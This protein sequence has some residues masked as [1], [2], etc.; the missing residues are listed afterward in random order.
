MPRVAAPDR[1]TRRDLPS[2]GPTQQFRPPAMRRSA[3][4]AAPP[5]PMERP[6]PQ[7]APPPQAEIQHLL[8]GLAGFYRCKADAQAAMQQLRQVHG[9]QSAQLVLLGPADGA[10]L[11]FIW[12]ARQWN[13]SPQGTGRPITGPLVS[14][15]LAGALVGLVAGLAFLDID[16]HQSIELELELAALAAAVLCGAALAAGAV[17]LLRSQQPQY[18]DFDRTVRRKLKGGAWTVLVHRL[19]WAQQSG[20]VAAVRRQGRQWCAVSSARRHR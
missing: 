18:I 20:A 7:P 8:D 13:R 3:S 15:G 11:R 5:G 2:S 1:A 10:W 17:G 16:R 9:L 4:V 14:I 19:H 12:L 6:V